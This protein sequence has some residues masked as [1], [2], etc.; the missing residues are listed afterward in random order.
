MQTK[1]FFLVMSAILVIQACTTVRPPGASVNVTV[2]SQASPMLPPGGSY[3]LSP[4]NKGVTDGDPEFRAYADYLRRA[5]SDRGF[6]PARKPTQAT[7]S[8]VLSYGVVDPRP[9]GKP[10]PV[11]MKTH[12]NAG[13]STG[14]INPDSGKRALPNGLSAASSYGMVAQAT[15]SEAETMYF[16]YVEIDAYRAGTSAGKR[17]WTT[18][19]TSLGPSGDLSRVFPYLAVAAARHLASITD[20]PASEVVHESD[21]S[22][23]GN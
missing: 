16:R 5:L 3:L 6:F 2:E 19:A 15:A 4:G 8:I 23:L 1:K 11:W 18:R 22:A 12:F 21:L 9:G 13:T 20:R 17:L 7:I 14:L 10:S